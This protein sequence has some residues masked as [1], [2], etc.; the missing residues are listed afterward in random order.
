MRLRGIAVA[1]SLLLLGCVRTP[2]AMPGHALI[3]FEAASLKD[4]FGKL[5]K[6]FEA[7]NPGVEVI[8]NA[9]GSQELRTQIE[10]GAVADVIASADRRHM[11]PVAGQGLVGSPSVFSC[12]EP[13]LVV[14]AELAT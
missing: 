6:R 13:V 11:D 3:V 12:N 8:A 9:A 14:R 5:G 7:D 4:V 2:S 1:A 10:H